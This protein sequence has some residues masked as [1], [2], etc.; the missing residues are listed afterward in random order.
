MLIAVTTSYLNLTDFVLVEKI[1]LSLREP[2]TFQHLSVGPPHVYLVLF[3]DRLLN[4]CKLQISECLYMC[5]VEI[6]TQEAAR[7]NHQLYFSKHWLLIFGVYTTTA[8][9]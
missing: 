9:V 6:V 1:P 7:L 4:G 3:G 5:A 2:P 8:F